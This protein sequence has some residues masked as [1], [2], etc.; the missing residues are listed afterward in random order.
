MWGSLTLAPI[1]LNF[2]H[3][4]YTFFCNNCTSSHKKSIT[5][6]MEHISVRQNQVLVLCLATVSASVSVVY[7]YNLSSF[8]QVCE[9]GTPLLFL[10]HWNEQKLVYSELPCK[11]ASSLWFL[12]RVGYV[13][14][15]ERG[16]TGVFSR[17]ASS[18]G[19]RRVAGKRGIVIIITGWCWLSTLWN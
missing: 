13:L 11:P 7:S 17:E 9:M 15:R 18:A 14:D 12:S 3:A 6:I 2:V 5:Y 4:Y 10:R 8:I 1:I 16:R 19:K